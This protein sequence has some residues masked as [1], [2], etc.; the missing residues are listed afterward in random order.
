V[1]QSLSVY[2]QLVLAVGQLAVD[3]VAQCVVGVAVVEHVTTKVV[4]KLCFRWPLCWLVTKLLKSKYF[5]RSQKT[6]WG[7]LKIRNYSRAFHT[8]PTSGLGVLCGLRLAV[9]ELE[10]LYTLRFVAC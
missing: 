8:H 10:V 5:R 3:Q 2:P 7:L 9:S 4:W 1:G 6:Y